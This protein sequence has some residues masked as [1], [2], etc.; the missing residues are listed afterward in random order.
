MSNNRRSL[1]TIAAEL[2]AVGYSW[3]SIGKRVQRQAKTCSTWPN[4]FQDEWEPIYRA[5]QLRR[6]D[7]TNN[8]AHGALR[9]LLHADDDRTRLKSVEIWLRCGAS[10]LGKFQA[11]TPKVER[12]AETLAKPAIVQEFEQLLT[13]INHIAESNGNPP[14]TN[15]DELNATILREFSDVFEPRPEPKPVYLDC[16][17]NTLPP[18][19]ASH[20]DPIRIE[21]NNV[22]GLGVLL[23]AGALTLALA[24]RSNLAF[25]PESKKLSPACAL[26]IRG[27]DEGGRAPKQW[28]GPC[29]TNNPRPGATM[30]ATTLIRSLFAAKPSTNRKPRVERQLSIDSLEA[31]EVPAYLSGGTLYIDGTSGAD[32]VTVTYSAGSGWLGT[33]PK[34]T[35]KQNGTSQTFSPFAI[36]AGKVRFTGSGG[37][38]S[39]T[40]NSD[41][42]AFADGGI[43]ND[44]L[45]GGWGNDTLKGNDGSDSLYG[46]DGND[47][48]YGEKEIFAFGSAGNDFLDGG[49]GNDTLSGN[50][51]NDSLVGGAG[52]NSLDGGDGYDTVI[53]SGDMNFRLT[54]Y[55]LN[56]PGVDQLTDIDAATLTGGAGANRIDAQ[57]FL[58][59]VAMYGLAGNDT[60]IG[61]WGND[62][63]Y[64]GNNND[65][66]EAGSDWELADGGSGTDFNAH[67]WAISGTAGTDI[68]QQKAG[69]CVFLSAL[70]GAANQGVDL[71]SRI[72]YLGD[73]NYRVSLYDTNAGWVDVEVPFNGMMVRGPKGTDDPASNQTDPVTSVD[74]FWTIVYQRAYLQHFE[75]INIL[76]GNAVE[77]FRGESTNTRALAAVTGSATDEFHLDSNAYAWLGSDYLNSIGTA[78]AI[79]KSSGSVMNVA[80]E[81]HAYSVMNVYQNGYGEWRV[82][83]YN[84]WGTDITHNGMAFDTIDSD[85][86][87]I[88]VS[89]A[90][91]TLVDAQIG[92][93]Y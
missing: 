22:I 70:T 34:Y 2:R 57:G 56:G 11:V 40:N 17:G 36:T 43:G 52:S 85:N 30:S 78:L 61:G 38:D 79:A 64:G 76:D 74:E 92:Y 8:E 24:G 12:I 13:G 19:P 32:T 89:L 21:R 9:G 55:Q 62:S 35:V 45:V 81:K 25:Q 87:I 69:T 77:A 6:F 75:G 28:S 14:A 53:A 18:P 67:L 58:G 47:T 5:A 33:V 54:N 49:V 1:L 27:G 59:N 10:A 72:I 82:T 39:F 50:A 7:E 3:E 63:L 42:A 44:T 83:I 80:F 4:R 60:L 51:G 41:L 65:W 29:E 73:F 91:L 48:I 37:N 23:L 68:V 66:L 88:E 46:A 93:T 15:F 90:D 26:L 84:P 31:R 71:Q 16:E 86:G 20:P